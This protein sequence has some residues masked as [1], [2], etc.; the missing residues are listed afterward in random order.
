MKKPVLNILNRSNKSMV[1][2]LMYLDDVLRSEVFKDATDIYKAEFSDGVVIEG[3]RIKN[4]WKFVVDCR[5]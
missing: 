4:G 3:H 5:R 2:V 1:N